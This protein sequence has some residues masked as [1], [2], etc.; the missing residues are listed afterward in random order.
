M[1]TLYY[2]A[3]MASSRTEILKS[4]LAQNPADSFARYGLAMEFVNSGA[5][6]DAVAQF[7]E[8][9]SINPDYVASYFHCGQTL[10]KLGRTEDA[11]QAYRDGIEVAKRKQDDHT[12]SELEAALELLA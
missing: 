3:R 7:R 9:M 6:E 10:E 12:R 8:L 1:R 11:R 5:L 4:M 2:H